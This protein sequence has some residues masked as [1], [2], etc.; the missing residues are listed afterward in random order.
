[1]AIS[2]ARARGALLPS[3][4]VYPNQYLDQ[5]ADTDAFGGWDVSED[6]WGELRPNTARLLSAYTVGPIRLFS[7][8]SQ[9]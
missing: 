6:E 7:I 1:M 8:F 5:D 3:L 9:K 2:V 4:R